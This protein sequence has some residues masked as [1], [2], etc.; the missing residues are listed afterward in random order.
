MRLG[1]VRL[2]L[3]AAAAGH[4]AG[5]LAVPATL[6]V[7]ARVIDPQRYFAVYVLTIYAGVALLRS[8]LSASARRAPPSSWSPT[9]TP[10]RRR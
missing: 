8:V 7:V 2:A 4:C 5:A 6:R 1:L 10:C 3:S 9:R